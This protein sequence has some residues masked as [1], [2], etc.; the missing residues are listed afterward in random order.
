MSYRPLG[1]STAVSSHTGHESTPRHFG[2]ESS[3]KLLTHPW[4]EVVRRGKRSI[5]WTN[6][7][8][9]QKRAFEHELYTERSERPDLLYNN[10][11]TA[12]PNPVLLDVHMRLA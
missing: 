9:S 8:P 3:G 5:T 7:A 6:G 4:P 12:G 1:Q 2:Q 11:L 10:S